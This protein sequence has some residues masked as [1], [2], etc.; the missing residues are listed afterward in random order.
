LKK[1]CKNKKCA[2]YCYHGTYLST[3]QEHGV[4]LFAE[5]KISPKIGADKLFTLKWRRNNVVIFEGEG[6]LCD[7]ILI[8]D[9]HDTK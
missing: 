8:V 7:G 5:L 6:M 4:P 2:N 1:G 9:Y 3:W